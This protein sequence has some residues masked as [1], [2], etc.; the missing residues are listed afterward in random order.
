MLMM[1]SISDSD[2]SSHTMADEENLGI[3][4]LTLYYIEKGF[5]NRST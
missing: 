3:T 5:E 4:M 2:R 1:D